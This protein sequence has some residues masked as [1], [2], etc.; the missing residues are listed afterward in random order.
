[1]T[2]WENQQR[3]P[4]DRWWFMKAPTNL[5][6]EMV[7]R[8]MLCVKEYCYDPDW[9]QC[10]ATRRCSLFVYSKSQWCRRCIRERYPYCWGVLSQWWRMPS[11]VQ[12]RLSWCRDGTSWIARLE[13]TVSLVLATDNVFPLFNVFQGLPLRIMDVLWLFR[14]GDR[15]PTTAQM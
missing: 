5:I 9:W 11:D 14:I 10:F 6:V 4:M 2:I 13:K 1:M 12:K 8:T 3:E 7:Q 15:P